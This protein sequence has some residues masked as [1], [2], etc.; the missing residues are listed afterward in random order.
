M[1]NDATVALT[2]T[3]PFIIIVSAI[4]ALV[5]SFFLLLL[6][7]RAVVQAMS[8]LAGVP[9]KSTQPSFASNRPSGIS[10][11]VIEI[12][13]SAV[14][15]RSAS[16]SKGAYLQA[17]QSLNRLTLAYA[18]AG[19]GYALVFAVVMMFLAG[20]DSS[21]NR[22][23]VLLSFYSWPVA[24]SCSLINSSVGKR[25]FIYY[26]VIVMLIAI[27]VLLR[28]SGTLQAGE[29]ILLWL[30]TNG[31]ATV[32]LLTF[33]NR[34]VRAVGPLVLVFM[35]IATAGSVATLS[36]VGGNQLLLGR[37]ADIGAVLGLDGVVIFFL[38]LLTGFIL[39]GV[40]GWPL[41]QLFGRKYQQK[42]MS[43]QAITIDAVYLL[44]GVVQSITLV[45]DGHVFIFTG[46]VAFVVYKFVFQF[47]YRLLSG[48]HDKECSKKQ[49]LLLR[50]FSLGKK[51]ERLFD[52]IGSVWLRTGNINLIAGPDLATSTVEPHEFLD[53]MGGHLS[54]QFVKGDED[55]E[56]RISGMDNLPD[57]DGRY[58][59]NE[60]FC[61]ADTWQMT[62]QRLAS[63]SDAVLMDLRRLSE[64]NR[65]CLYEL[66]QIFNTVPL[67]SVIFVIDDSTD[68]NFLEK[69][70][71]EIWET[72]TPTSPNAKLSKPVV[73][74]FLIRNGS[75]N[76][77]DKLLSILYDAAV[78][79]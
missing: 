64:K 77:T 22:F 57:P 43:E 40:I 31:P 13:E 15:E 46:I 2:G 32:L 74:C 17:V 50:V 56:Q 19:L 48:R 45:F 69:S 18:I 27:L 58:R 51:S 37:V 14:R 65:G 7:R 3:F 71:R 34:R 4:L 28:N 52:T 25:V 68:R 44:F 61:R 26:V 35:I 78:A 38:V 11:P 12:M 60:F 10:F 47:V 53:F 67:E 16:H 1:S 63:K 79:V 66:H 8:A 30:I 55:L 9:S 6:Y 62:M 41:L 5:V 42:R 72:L 54:R 20:A 39:F 33:L 24:F 59:V 75:I 49:L 76:E 73:L 23:L 36:V 21:V 29:L 70:C